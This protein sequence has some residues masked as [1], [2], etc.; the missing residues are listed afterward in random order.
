MSSF[1]KLSKSDVSVVPY[2]ANKQWDLSITCFPTTSDY[3]TIYKGTNLTSSFSSASDPKSEGQYERLIYTQINQLFYQSYT[4]SLDTRSLASSIYY[5]SASQQRPTSSYFIYNDNVNFINNFPTGASDSIRVI[6]I[7]QNVYGN[8]VLPNS[9]VLTSSAYSVKDDGYGNLYDGILTGSQQST[10]VAYASDGVKLY[11]P[12]YNTDGTGTN[13]SWNTSAGGGSYAGTFWTNPVTANKT[14]RLNYT[15][16]WSGRSL[17]YLGTGTLTFNITASS[18]T[19]YYFGIGC[20]NLASIYLDN[21]LLFTQTSIENNGANFRYW[22]IYPVAVSSG[23][24]TVKLLG[25]NVGI[26]SP[27]NPASMGIEIYNNTSTQISASIAASP[28]GSSIPSG[29]DVVYSSKDHLTE[30]DFS[31]QY[32]TH[33]GNLFYAQ[34]LAVI[35]NPDYQLMFPTASCAPTTTTT[36]TTTTTTTAEPT[37]TTSTTTT[38]TTAEPT[39]TS[40]TTTTTTT[41]PT[42]TT[43]TSTTTTTTTAEPTTTTTTSTTTT[44]T[45]A[46]PTTT[47]TTSTT[48]TTTTADPY[49]YYSVSKFDCG[50]SCAY[51]SPDLVA[52]S[53]TPLSTIDGVYYKPLGSFTY[54]IQTT[55]SGPSYNID[56]DGAPSNANCISA[57]S[58]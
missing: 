25:E 40:T 48:T 52:R 54:Q 24:H 46:E 56:L 50:S 14:G 36:S 11:S 17:T 41:E 47:T 10:N 39:T 53:S 33:I 21:I 57:C 22:H 31:N 8:K 43:T 9:F 16:L 12:G 37:T 2:Y 28:N 58:L 23:S 30:G 32:G 42:T 49:Y 35:T 4:A 13:I 51:V 44:T 26:P 27:G 34:G 38:T 5:E 55:V 45:T 3:L 7:N 1:K 29:I 18:N 6:T 15:G 19:T 20:D